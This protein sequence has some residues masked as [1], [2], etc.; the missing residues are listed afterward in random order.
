MNQKELFIIS[1]TVFLTIVAWMLVDV[2]KAKTDTS[3]GAQ[4]TIKPGVNYK[5]DPAI[6]NRLKE[7]TE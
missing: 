6:L 7:K 3:I 1:I 4:Y 5:L 2:Y